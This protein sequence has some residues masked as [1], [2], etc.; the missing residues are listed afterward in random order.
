MAY[1]APGA[2]PQGLSLFT[3]S[4]L[5]NHRSGLSSLF[6]DTLAVA[7]ERRPTLGS[8]LRETL[9]GTPPP[10]PARR[11]GLADVMSR[12]GART[13]T[14]SFSDDSIWHQLDRGERVDVTLWRV[15]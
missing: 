6:P 1:D 13:V 9:A 10:P 5:N 11:P 15:S 7:S 14:L 12:T 4:P 2:P 8:V 3:R